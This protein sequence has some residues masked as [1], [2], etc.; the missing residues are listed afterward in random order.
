MCQ[1][2]SLNLS[3]STPLVHSVSPNVF[4]FYRVKGKVKGIKGTAKQPCTPQMLLKKYGKGQKSAS[5]YRNFSVGAKFFFLIK[6]Y[7]Y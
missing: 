6:I 4:V 3:T 5:D 7:L 2:I 1:L